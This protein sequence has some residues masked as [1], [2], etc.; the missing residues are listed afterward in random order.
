MSIRKASWTKKKSFA[1]N[2]H[3]LFFFSLLNILKIEFFYNLI[4]THEEKQLF[5]KNLLFLMIRI[6][7][8]S[9]EKCNSG[10]LMTAIQ[11]TSKP[12]IDASIK[13]SEGNREK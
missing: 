9:A 13:I 5:F 10:F 2:S 1:S 11:N 6:I 12:C 8:G 7:F 4:S 3:L